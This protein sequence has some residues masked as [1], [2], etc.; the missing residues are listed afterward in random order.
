MHIT[1]FAGFASGDATAAQ[2]NAAADLIA[3]TPGLLEARIY[4]QATTQDPY[5]D[6][7]PPPPLVL[8]LDFSDIADLEAALAPR[9]HLQGL[10]SALPSLADATQQAMLA[11]HF[12]V[13]DPVFRTRPGQLPCTYLVAYEGRAADPNAWHAHY[14]AHHPGIMAR[15][16][17][18]RAI[19]ICTRLDWTGFLPF[20]RVEHMQ[21]NKVVFDDE[22]ALHAALNSPVR[23]E[24]RTDFRR[25]PAFTGPTTH[26]PMHTRLVIPRPAPSP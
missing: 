4:T 12:P 2:T 7:A 1:W 17:G 22:Q 5:L 21:R 19:E 6:E 23:H 8:Q 24:M 16:P 9:G 20:R 18:I 10:P 11:R 25:F 26:Y 3:G 15:F 14:F 13:P